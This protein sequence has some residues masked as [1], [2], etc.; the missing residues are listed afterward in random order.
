[1]AAVNKALDRA[2]A[3]AP[4]TVSR[5]VSQGF[6]YLRSASNQMSFEE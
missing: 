6:A 5:L 2:S 4:Q 1:M 3:Q